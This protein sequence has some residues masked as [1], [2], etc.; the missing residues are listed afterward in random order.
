MWLV[1]LR[2][3]PAGTGDACGLPD[4]LMDERKPDKVYGAAAATLAERLSK[5]PVRLRAHT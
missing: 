3:E 5:R 1:T 4:Q 2:R